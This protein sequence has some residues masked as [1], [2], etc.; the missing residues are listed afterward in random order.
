MPNAKVRPRKGREEV[1]LYTAIEAAER[2]TGRGDRHVYRELVGMRADITRAL[3]RIEVIDSR[4]TDSDKFHADHENRLRTLERFRFSLLG[5][6]VAVSAEV[7]AAG[8][9][10][11]FALTH[12]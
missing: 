4:S 8:T 10:I 11:G 12:R 2:L 7:S 5:A 9:W 3:T 6:A 1:V